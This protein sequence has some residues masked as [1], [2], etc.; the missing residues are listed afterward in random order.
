M[1]VCLLDDLIKYRTPNIRSRKTNKNYIFNKQLLNR[2]NCKLYH[3]PKNNLKGIEKL[4]QKTI[5]E[6]DL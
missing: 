3:I 6:K 5:V 1:S 4:L 2:C